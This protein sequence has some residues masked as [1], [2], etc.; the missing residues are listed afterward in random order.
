MQSFDVAGVPFGNGELSFLLGPCVVE[1]QEHALFMASSVAEICVRVGV[2]FVYKSSFDKANR[3]SIESFRG[4][5]ME[6]GLEILAKVKDEIGV[7]VVTDIHEPWQAEKAA[8]VADVLQIPA[9]LC[10]QTDLLVAAA[11]TG[12]AVN[13]KKGQFLAPWDAKNIVEKLQAA[14]C[15]KII[16]TERGA[17]FGYNNLVVDLRSF[18]IMRGFGVPVCF[19][20]TH[21]LQLPGGLGKATGG[22][23]AYIEN[24]ARAG[25]ACGVDAVFMEVHDNP[26]KAPSDGPNQLPLSRLEDLLTK[27]K[28]IHELVNEKQESVNAAS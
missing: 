22:Q 10:R 12:K 4:E 6:F 17:S 5:G 27:L 8:E 18:P 21:S 14:G 1:S 15:E 28:A 11:K 23:S 20:V 26:A 2:K 7:P 16:L 25:V 9:F 3:S 24:F 13:V 19:D